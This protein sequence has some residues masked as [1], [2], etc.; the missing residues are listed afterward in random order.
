MAPIAH[1][2][3]R[4]GQEFSLPSG[5]VLP[6]TALAV[7]FAKRLQRCRRVV[8]SSCVKGLAVAF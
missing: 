5:R 7:P 1:G 6:C 4:G 8:V 3:S 2:Y